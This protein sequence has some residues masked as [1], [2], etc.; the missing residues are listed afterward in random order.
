LP[1]EREGMRGGTVIVAGDAGTGVGDRMRLG[2][3]AV[4]GS[5]G[6]FSGARMSAGTIVVG[7]DVGT[8]AGAV[9]RRGTILAPRGNLRT[10][11]GFADSG[12]HDLAVQRLLARALT[13]HGLSGLAEMLHGLRRWQGDLAV[14]GKGEIWTA[15]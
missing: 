13:K 2:L 5:V 12:A 1:G 11:P 8:G 15:P 3:I 7:G 9:M 14:N 4:L 10:L 6:P